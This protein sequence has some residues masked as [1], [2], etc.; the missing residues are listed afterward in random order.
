M[1]FKGSDS[2]LFFQIILRTQWLKIC[3]DLIVLGTT[4]WGTQDLPQ[5]NRKKQC[6][7]A[8]LIS[9]FDIQGAWGD[10]RRSLAQ[11]F[12]HSNIDAWPDFHMVTLPVRLILLDKGVAGD[13]VAGYGGGFHPST[14][15]S[16]KTHAH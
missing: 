8:K 6:L 3:E 5:Y 13:E 9:N 14:C 4:K 10:V 1:L 15:L 2:D 12:I 16:R 11:S 7:S